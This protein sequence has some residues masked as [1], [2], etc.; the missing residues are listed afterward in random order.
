MF[1]RVV[2]LLLALAASPASAA[3]FVKRTVPLQCPV[4]L[5]KAQSRIREQVPGMRVVDRH[6]AE[7]AVER[8]SRR[9]ARAKD[10]PEVDAPPPAAGDEYVFVEGVSSAT[11]PMQRLWELEHHLRDPRAKPQAYVIEGSESAGYFLESVIAELR[12]AERHQ[13][14]PTLRRRGW[15]TVKY[16]SAAFY[17]VLAPP[18]VAL[19]IWFNAP[20]ALIIAPAAGL[21]AGLMALHSGRKASLREEVPFLAVGDP[22][23]ETVGDADTKALIGFGA[24]YRPSRLPSWLSARGLMTSYFTFTEGIHRAA[25]TDVFLEPAEGT[26]PARLWIFG[27]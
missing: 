22:L 5:A 7:A 20:P 26:Q 18:A 14:P 8:L 13:G 25:R 1:F 12:A 11:V 6:E 24:T 9:I 15:I 3:W 21:I 19:G 27:W 10:Q 2:P 17:L 4:L 23:R 16:I